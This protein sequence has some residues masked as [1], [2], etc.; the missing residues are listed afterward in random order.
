MRTLHTSI[1]G[2]I[3]PYGEQINRHHVDWR[4]LNLSRKH[5]PKPNLNTEVRRNGMEVLK[6]WT[7][8]YQTL[9][10][11]LIKGCREWTRPRKR[12]ESVV[13]FEEVL[14][15]KSKHLSLVLSELEWNRNRQ[16]SECNATGGFNEPWN[17]VIWDCDGK[18]Q[19]SGSAVL[20]YEALRVHPK[21]M[22]AGWWPFWW[23]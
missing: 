5:Q 3:K 7:D 4:A 8:E 20:A 22:I 16:E 9:V 15:T 18:K 21:S 19:K 14:G 12:G 13:L 2:L 23:S 17:S 1:N 10:Q 6:K 11:G